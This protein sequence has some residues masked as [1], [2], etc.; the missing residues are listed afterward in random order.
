VLIGGTD[1]RSVIAAAIGSA[2]AG[3]LEFLPACGLIVAAEHAKFGISEVKPGLVTTGG[4][5]L[6]GT[7]KCRSA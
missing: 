4:T 7:V 1:S 6:D 2:R 5:R 3:G